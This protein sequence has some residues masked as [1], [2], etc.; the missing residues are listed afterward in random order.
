MDAI[1]TEST[2]A[3]ITGSLTSLSRNMVKVWNDGFP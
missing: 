2:E 3:V 1:V